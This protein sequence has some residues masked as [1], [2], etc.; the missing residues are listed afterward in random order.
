MTMWSVNPRRAAPMSSNRSITRRYS[1]LVVSLRAIPRYQPSMRASERIHATEAGPAGE[2]QPPPG[3]PRGQPWPVG[4]DRHRHRHGGRGAGAEMRVPG[5][6]EGW[7]LDLKAAVALLDHPADPYGRGHQQ[8]PR[9]RGRQIPAAAGRF[10]GAGG[11][12]GFGG[13]GGPD[14]V[15][16]FLGRHAGTLRIGRAR[17]AVRRSRV[18]QRSDSAAGDQPRTAGVRLSSGVVRAGERG[19]RHN[20]GTCATDLSE[21]V[22]SAPPPALLFPPGPPSG[23]VRCAGSGSRPY[24]VSCSSPHHPAVRHRPPVVRGVQPGSRRGERQ[25]SGQGVAGVLPVRLAH[26]AALAVPADP[27]G[28]RHP[29]HRPGPGPAGQAVVG[30]PEALRAAARRGRPGT[31]W[32]ACRCCCSWAG[33][34]SRS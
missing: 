23:A 27:G 17:W 13:F 3:E 11:L 32:S 33:R 9:R 30:G 28:P 14:A 8:N 5:G 25:D 10:V 24:S 31:P 19:P 4:D 22:H 12:G 16:S 26:R 2:Q 18:T 6:Q 29:R 21:P 7:P 20:V 34:S 15:A 1:C